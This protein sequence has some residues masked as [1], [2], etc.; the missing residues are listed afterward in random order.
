MKLS[1]FFRSLCISE[2]YLQKSQE[3]FNIQVD[4]KV[5]LFYQMVLLELFK[6][7]QNSS[8]VCKKLQK[9]RESFKS[10]RN[11]LE[12]LK[13]FTNPMNSSNLLERFKSQKSLKFC[14]KNSEK[15][16]LKFFKKIHKKN[17]ETLNIFKSFILYFR[18]F[19]MFLNSF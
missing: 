2:V 16:S 12:V 4:P 1:K 11:A 15:H 13:I 18:N 3:L 17:L 14:K 7:A 19:Q 6:S 10:L 9:L 5:S 8:E